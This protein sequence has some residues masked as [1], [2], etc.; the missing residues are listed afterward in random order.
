VQLTVPGWLLLLEGRQQQLDSVLA[1]MCICFSVLA[2]S[3]AI[4]GV[5]SQWHSWFLPGWAMLSG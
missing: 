4:D 3:S 1:C 5:G 2:W